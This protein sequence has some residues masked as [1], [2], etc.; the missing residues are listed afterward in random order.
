MLMTLPSLSYVYV[1]PGAA[2]I[3]LSAK[4]VKPVP[5]RF[6]LRHTDNV[7]RAESG[8]QANTADH[9]PLSLIASVDRTCSL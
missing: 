2:V 4:T 1:S 3:R 8:D 5:A 9:R 6:H 7:R